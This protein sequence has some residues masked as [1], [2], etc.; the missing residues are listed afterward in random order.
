MK[1][2]LDFFSEQR[3]TVTQAIDSLSISIN[4]LDRQKIPKIGTGPYLL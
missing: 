1:F 2:Q 4:F 3:L